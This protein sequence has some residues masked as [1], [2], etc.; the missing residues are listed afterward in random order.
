M[1][2]VR[3][4]GKDGQRKELNEEG[5]RAGTLNEFLKGAG[6][7]SSECF[8]GRFNLYFQTSNYRPE[9][10]FPERFA[11]PTCSGGWSVPAINVKNLI[12]FLIFKNLVTVLLIYC[13]IKLFTFILH[14][15]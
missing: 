7:F 10:I 11:L 12:F 14:L 2:A 4:V 3:V 8:G 15:E 1:P 6:V 9:E 13:Y 5:S